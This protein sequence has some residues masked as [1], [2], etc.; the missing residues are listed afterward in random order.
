MVA[1]VGAV[2]SIIYAHSD[3]EQ[4]V[5]FFPTQITSLILGVE[6]RFWYVYNGIG[7]FLAHDVVFNIE[8]LE[9]M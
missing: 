4:N 7:L 3:V 5:M 2:H 9:N 8:L 1:S 6:S